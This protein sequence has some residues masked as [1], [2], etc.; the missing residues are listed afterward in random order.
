[1]GRNIA[2]D[3]DKAIHRATLLF[4]RQGYTNTSLR[5]L[6]KAMH[7]GEGSFYN[8]V[9]SK[10]ALFLECLKHYGETVGSK[11]AAALFSQP[12]VK[13]GIRALFNTVLDDLDNP[14]N[15]RMCFMANSVSCDVVKESELRQFLEAAMSDFQSR[16]VARLQK[17]VQSGE[18]PKDFDSVSVAAIVATFMQG[19]LRGVIINYDRRKIERQV[20]ILLTGLGF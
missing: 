20:E 17:A 9:K 4:W 5:D 10:K 6:L 8:T 11:R 3:Y 1:M 2:F 19:L 14:A 7:I 13:K 18:L 15:P 12:S 16:F